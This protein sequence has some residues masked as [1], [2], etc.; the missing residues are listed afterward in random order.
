MRWPLLALVLGVALTPSSGAAQS[1]S[2]RIKF[3]CPSCGGRARV[4]IAFLETV[5]VQIGVNLINQFIIVDSS[6]DVT[7]ETWARN[8]RE[9]WEFDANHFSTNQFA[10]PYS[11]NINFNAARANGLD[12]WSSIPFA[13]LGSLIWEYFGEIHRPS[14]NDYISTTVGGVALGELTFQLSSLVLDN[15]ATGKSRFWKE[16]AGLAINPARGVNRFL[17]GDWD[18]VGPNSPDRTPELMRGG[19]RVGFRLVDDGS[20]LDQASFHPF[21]TFDFLHGDPFEQSYTKPFDVFL[22]NAQ[23]NAAESRVIGRLTAYG[24]LY[25]K[26]L[27]SGERPRHALLV[28]QNYDYYNTDAFKLGGQSVDV[29]VMS[30]FDLS[31]RLRLQTTLMGKGIILAAVNSEFEDGPNRDY[32][33]GPGLGISVGG[34]LSR[35]GLQIA[36][37]S[38][39]IQTIHNVN[40]LA[41]NHYLH[42]AVVDAS[43]PLSPRM[44]VGGQGLFYHRRSNYRNLPSVTQ[45]TPEI[46]A[47]LRWG[48]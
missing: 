9:G 21:I 1:D 18:R 46:Q 37:L 6:Q 36:R 30:R 34:T 16:M 10:H 32:D 25:W 19:M 24:R 14:L 5:G 40:G 27:D 29:G 44:S 15:E 38:Y 17:F 41:G 35:G 33:Y 22:F 7:P 12:Y 11:G 8:L 45:D 48:F 4:G 13:A 23:L 3:E 42:E 2:V 43:V 31:S 39:A 47:Y 28:T 20:G 26:R